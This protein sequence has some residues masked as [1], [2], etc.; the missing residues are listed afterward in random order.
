[1][2]IKEHLKKQINFE[3]IKDPETF[4]VFILLTTLILTLISTLHFIH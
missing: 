2:L 3:K 4:S 1:M